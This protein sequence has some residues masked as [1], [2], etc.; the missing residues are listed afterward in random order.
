MGDGV[1]QVQPLWSFAGVTLAD[2]CD[3][4]LIPRQVM[5]GVEV[6]ICSPE[7][8]LGNRALG[9]YS[10]LWLVFDSMISRTVIGDWKVPIISEKFTQKQ[11]A[12]VRVEAQLYEHYPWWKF[13]LGWYLEFSLRLER[14]PHRLY[15]VGGGGWLHQRIPFQRRCRSDQVRKDFEMSCW[16]KWNTLDCSYNVGSWNGNGRP[17]TLS[18]T[19]LGWMEWAH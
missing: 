17:Y 14:C 11:N 4:C 18:K 9:R 19:T 10:S 13:D 2:R 3:A 7:R 8:S 16:W 12:V 5:L 15:G 1:V 6:I